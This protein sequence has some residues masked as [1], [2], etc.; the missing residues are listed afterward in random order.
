[1]VKIAICRTCGRKISQVWNER[2]NC[3]NCGGPLE[4][5]EVEMGFSDRIPRVLNVGGVAFMVFAILYIF[6]KLI[7]G[8]IGKDSGINIIILFLAGICF[9]AASLIVQFHLSNKAKVNL[10]D[11]SV[12]RKQRRVKTRSDHD[13]DAVKT[14]KVE[15]PRRRTASKVPIRK[16]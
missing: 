6:Y 12:D 2:S 8:G 4:Q 10:P 7:D 15:P 13:R 5:L 9:F 3:T 11:R 1:L 16:R 14:G